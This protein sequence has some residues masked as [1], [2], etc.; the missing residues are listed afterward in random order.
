MN[1]QTKVCQNCKKNFIINPDD[2]LFYERMKVPVPTFCSQCRFARRLAWRNERSLYKRTC[3]L[4][5]KDMIS[6]YKANTTF[7]VYCHECWWSDKW[8][9]IEYGKDYDFSKSFFDC[10]IDLEIASS[11]IEALRMV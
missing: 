11:S 8:D 3:D 10:C 6:M 9:S 2:L 7:P 5:K 1:S 4:C